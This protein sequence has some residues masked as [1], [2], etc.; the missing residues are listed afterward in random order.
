MSKNETLI[1]ERQQIDALMISFCS[2]DVLDEFLEKYG[3][4]CF[5]EER[6]RFYGEKYIARTLLSAVV[7]YTALI[8]KINY[9][10]IVKKIVEAGADINLRNYGFSGTALNEWVTES[11]LYVVGRILLEAGAVTQTK[12]YFQKTCMESLVYDVCDICRVNEQKI[13]IMI[14]GGACDAVSGLLRKF[15][16]IFGCITKANVVQLVFRIDLIIE[17]MM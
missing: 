5:I 6:T 8:G 17:N 16:N 13:K 2:P 3:V 4:N 12:G 11:R 7:S 14:E 9:T 1:L 15:C 10:T